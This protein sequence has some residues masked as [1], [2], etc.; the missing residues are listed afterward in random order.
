MGG[1]DPRMGRNCRQGLTEKKKGKW[2]DGGPWR[3][4]RWK[5]GSWRG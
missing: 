3:G 1:G 2:M 4:K 5:R